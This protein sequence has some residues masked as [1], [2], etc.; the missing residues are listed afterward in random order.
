M[1][2]WDTLFWGGTTSAH[3]W[4]AKGFG[5]VASCPDYLYLDFPNEACLGLCRIVASEIEIEAPNKFL[6][7]I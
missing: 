2:F 6:N 5:V 7:L 1:N 3:E 4:G